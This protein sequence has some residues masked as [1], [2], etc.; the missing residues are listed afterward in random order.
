MG[1]VDLLRIPKGAKRFVLALIAI[2]AMAYGGFYLVLS[3]L[4]DSASW[5]AGIST[6]AG[7]AFT[8]Y[9]ATRR[10]EERQRT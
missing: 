6:L 8:F 9:F 5:F 3:G 10:E 4:L 7:S 1:L 2:T